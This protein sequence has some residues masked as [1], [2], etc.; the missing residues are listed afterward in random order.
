MRGWMLIR[1]SSKT[2]DDED[3]GNEPLIWISLF[4]GS[5]EPC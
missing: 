4:H 5:V 2:P 1:I 3:N